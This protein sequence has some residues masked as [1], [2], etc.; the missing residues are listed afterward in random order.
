VIAV[1]A[2]DQE[3]QAGSRQE[4]NGQKVIAVIR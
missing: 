3:K 1:I 2:R 4:A